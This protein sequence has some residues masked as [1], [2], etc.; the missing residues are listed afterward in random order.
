MIEDES[1]RPATHVPES[2]Y[3]R[4]TVLVLLQKIVDPGFFHTCDGIEAA[5]V[6]GVAR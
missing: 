3:Y 4:E 2:R 6:T 5:V 1:S